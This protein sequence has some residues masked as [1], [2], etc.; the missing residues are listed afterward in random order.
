MLLLCHWRHPVLGWPLD[1][2][3]VHARLEDSDLRPVQAR[4]TQRRDFA[5]LVLCA[6]SA[7]TDSDA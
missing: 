6:D 4:Y 5:A 3:R 1:G 7:W 2:A